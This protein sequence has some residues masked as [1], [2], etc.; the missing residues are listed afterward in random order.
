M[1][2]IPVGRRK[3][4]DYTLFFEKPFDIPTSGYAV[5]QKS[6]LLELNTGQKSQNVIVA[7]ITKKFGLAQLAER[8]NE[9]AMVTSSIPGDSN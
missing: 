4:F 3:L 2:D 6:G 9:E 1:L 8:R 7:F 5:T